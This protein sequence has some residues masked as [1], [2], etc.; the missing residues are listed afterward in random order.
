MLKPHQNEPKTSLLKTKQINKKK[1]GDPASRFTKERLSMSPWLIRWVI[2]P[3]VQA[4]E[5][6][7]NA[8]AVQPGLG[9]GPTK[10]VG[11]W[12]SKDFELGILGQVTNHPA[13][14]PLMTGSSDTSSTAGW[15]K[16]RGCNKKSGYEPAQS[17]CVSTPNQCLTYWMPSIWTKGNLR[18]LFAPEGCSVGTCWKWTLSTSKSGR[19]PLKLPKPASP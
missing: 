13:M 5:D 17:P 10:E 1:T 8:M 4:T 2:Q 15:S 19:K 6:Q 7:W 14:W 12:D 16:S 9:M 18:F 3:L 11:A